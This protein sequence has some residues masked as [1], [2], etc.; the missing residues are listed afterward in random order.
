[1]AAEVYIVRHGQDQDGARQILNGWRD[2]ELTLLGELQAEATAKVLG[3]LLSGREVTLYSSDQRRAIQTAE[4]I[5]S[6]LGL[7]GFMQF[8][9]LRERRLGIFTGLTITEVL[10]E[11]KHE[12]HLIE[13]PHTKYVEDPRYGCETFEKVQQR[14]R[15]FARYV[16][17]THSDDHSVVV[18]M[19]GDSG[20]ALAGAFVRKPMREMLD[21]PFKNGDILH[22]SGDNVRRIALEPIAA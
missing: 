18:A 12:S 4:P 16:W 11:V 20:R 1:M 22:I 15:Q 3:N 10:K 21:E 9:A 7:G 14:V 17:N 2:P 19:H 6:E 8:P 5:Q 13:T